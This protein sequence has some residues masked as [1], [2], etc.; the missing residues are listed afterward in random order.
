MAM[1]A[2]SAILA[3]LI[4]FLFSRFQPVRNFKVTGTPTAFTDEAVRDP[5]VIA[6]RGR[7]NA[8]A[9]TG[10]RE[11]SA[12]ITVT[13]KDGRRIERDIA[14]AVGSLERPLSDADINEKFLRQ[15][16]PILGERAAT[17]LLAM[18]WALDSEPSAAAIARAGAHHP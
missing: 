11:A 15:A 1:P 2:C 5:E 4:A 14:H 18:A 10:I 17:R 13:L 6:L 16:S 12:K 9:E 7:V 3:M 8:R